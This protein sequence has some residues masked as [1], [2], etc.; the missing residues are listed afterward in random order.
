M[1]LRWLVKALPVVFI[2]C[3]LVVGGGVVVGGFTPSGQMTYI[4][5]DNDI[6][7]LDADKNIALRVP[8]L[9]RLYGLDSSYSSDDMAAEMRVWIDVFNWSPDGRYLL[10]V[11]STNRGDQVAVYDIMSSTYRVISTDT[12]GVLPSWSPDSASIALVNR[13]GELCIVTVTD[14]KHECTGINLIKRALWSPHAN[15]IVYA[16]GWEGQTLVEIY[17]PAARTTRTLTQAYKID[18]LQWSPT[19]NQLAA[20][21]TPTYQA[22]PEVIII[23]V[24]QGITR[25]I[26]RGDVT[27]IAFNRW[28][29]DT[30]H[31]LFASQPYYVYLID[32][33]TG[34][35]YVG[36]DSYKQTLLGTQAIMP[37]EADNGCCRVTGIVDPQA[38]HRIFTRQGESFTCVQLMKDG[39]CGEGSFRALAWRP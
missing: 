8:L 28:K 32:I 25:T 17:D 12:D 10:Y 19:R 21:S 1:L 34:E 35:A 29:T 31:I 37:S 38:F 7:H 18:D 27:D 23:D 39:I 6:I 4:D 3:A 30:L 22:D 14:A 9:Q 16:R 5:Y 24:A 26:Y 15:R 20:I 11:F 2:I 36:L 13:A 33:E